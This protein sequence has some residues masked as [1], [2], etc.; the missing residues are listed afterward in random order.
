MD[1]K[2]DGMKYKVPIIK[3]HRDLNHSRGNMV[4]NIVVTKPGGRWGRDV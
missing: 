2:R 3:S 4:S 1:E